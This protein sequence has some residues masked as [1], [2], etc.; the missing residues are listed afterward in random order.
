MKRFTGGETVDAGLYFNVRQ[1][2][3]KSVDDTGP[4][5]GTGDD[6]YR[7]VPMLALLVV[8]PVLGLVYV[9]FLPFIGI[10]MV[11][12]LLGVKVAHMAA[13]AARETVHVLRPGWQPSMAFLSRSRPAKTP[14]EGTDEWAEEMRKKLKEGDRG[15]T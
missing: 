3:F 12:W 7:R 10:G 13:G 14:Q 6:V 15:T 4:L 8:G 1:L 2:S 11:T 9:L 5:P